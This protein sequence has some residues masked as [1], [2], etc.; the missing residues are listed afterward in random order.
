MRGR[1]LSANKRGVRYLFLMTRYRNR[2]HS[3]DGKLLVVG[4]LFRATQARWLQLS[5]TIRSKAAA[6]DR[7]NPRA[8]G[9][10]AGDGKKSKFVSA[11]DAYVINGVRNARWK[12]FVTEHEAEAILAHLK[13]RTNI[14]KELRRNVISL[15]RRSENREPTSQKACP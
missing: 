14:L 15:K 2:G 10:F 11:E 13:T 5:K 9:F 3:L 8:C 1:I 4:Y 7:E 12:Y 6:Y